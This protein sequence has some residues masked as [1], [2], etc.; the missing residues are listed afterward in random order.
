MDPARPER[1]REVLIVPFQD[2]VDDG[3]LHN[4]FGVKVVGA[5]YS[6][7]RAGAYKAWLRSSH[8]MVI[9]IPTA[10]STLLGS[11]G[12]Y[13]KERGRIGGHSETYEVARAVVR[14]RIL[15]ST[16]RGYYQLHI[17][18]PSEYDLTNAIFSPGTAPFG[19]IIPQ[20]TPVLVKTKV[21]ESKTLTGI[22]VDLAFRVS[23]VEEEPRR[24]IAAIRN[25]DTADALAKALHGMDFDD[26]IED[27]DM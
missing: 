8:E 19:P 7:Y 16:E 18:F 1:H 21:T 6:L 14:N 20:V 23:A 5:D 13:Q 10:R 22:E 15:A 4:G 11:Y 24:A 25:D 26:D 3:V 9:R 12:P 17:V 2:H 27:E